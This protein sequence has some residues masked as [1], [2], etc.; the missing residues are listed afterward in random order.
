MRKIAGKKEHD[1]K[2][3]AAEKLHRPA[4]MEDILL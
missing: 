3:T 4:T 2:A 1:N